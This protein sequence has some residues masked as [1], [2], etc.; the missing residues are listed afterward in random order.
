MSEPLRWAEW[1]TW[2]LLG[3]AYLVWGLATSLV[4]AVSLPLGIVLAALAAALHSSLTHE[5]LHGHPTRFRVLNGLLVGPALSLFIPYLRFRDTHLAHHHDESLTDPHDDPESNFLDPEVWAHLPRWLRLILRANNTLAGR[6]A[7][8]PLIS[9]VTFMAGDARAIWRGERRVL[10][11]W[12]LHI[13]ALGVVIWWALTAGQMP[14]WAYLLQGYLALSLLKIR[15]FLEH[16]AHLEAPG[17]SVVIEKP[18]PLSFLFLFNSLHIV[19]HSHPGVAWYRLPGLY[20]ANRAEFLA[21]NDGYAYASYAEVFRRYLFHPKD[22]VA[23]P[24]WPRR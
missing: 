9:Q 24:F 17:R 22:P 7:F 5:A 10:A 19:H 6:M 20:R 14:L 2:A 23:H 4:A 16:R 8:G 21:M 12:L 3:A 18:C 11:G 1:R 15:T 13:P